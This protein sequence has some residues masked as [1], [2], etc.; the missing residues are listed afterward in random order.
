MPS[1]S[2]WV[3]HSGRVDGF[4]WEKA[5][6]NWN[7]LGRGGMSMERLNAYGEAQLLWWEWP[8]GGA[9]AHLTKLNALPK[10][11]S[12]MLPAPTRWAVSKRPRRIS[13]GALLPPLSMKASY[14]CFAA[15]F[16]V[17]YVN[18]LMGSAGS[19]GY[20]TGRGVLEI[21]DRIHPRVKHFLYGKVF[22]YRFYSF[23]R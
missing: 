1:G 12:W 18:G 13:P 21:F 15:P 17:L 8:A 19:S 22:N 9:G 5:G 4:K 23:H 7:L 16:Q 6:R 14:A 10:H 20:S 3:W 11:R 2:E